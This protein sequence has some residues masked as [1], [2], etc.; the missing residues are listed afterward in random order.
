MIITIIEDD[1]NSSHYEKKKKIEKKLCALC[2]IYWT[3]LEMEKNVL[4]TVCLLFG[5]DIS[6]SFFI[7]NFMRFQ[8]A[9]GLRMEIDSRFVYAHCVCVCVW[10]Y[11]WSFLP[12]HSNSTVQ[13]S[14]VYACMHC[15]VFCVHCTRF[16]HFWCLTLTMM[17]VRVRV[18]CCSIAL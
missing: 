7:W 6:S 9:F 8:W 15:W 10:V 4:F 18:I 12:S 1:A 13:V 17:D 16:C 14:M 3:I 2:F 11:M 5:L